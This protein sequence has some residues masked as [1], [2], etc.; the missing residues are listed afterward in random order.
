MQ[1]L[2]E[3][4]LDSLES[5]ELRNSLSAAFDIDLPSTFAFDYP[6]ITA[7]TAYIC[8]H[9]RVA[10][11]ATLAAPS[12]TADLALSL[13]DSQRPS[14][15]VVGLVCR[16]PSSADGLAGFWAVAAGSHDVQCLVPHERWD[17]D[18]VYA[19]EAGPGRMAVTTR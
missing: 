8:A 12:A 14:L 4:G 18:Q 10:V 17:I 3:A 7:M 9:A 2:M 15:R 6:S 16:L 11:H 5:V 13:P 19:P 1:P